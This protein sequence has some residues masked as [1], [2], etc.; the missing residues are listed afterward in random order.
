MSPRRPRPYSTR[1]ATR[2]CSRASPTTTCRS[3]SEPRSRWRRHRSCSSAF[4]TTAEKQPRTKVRAPRCITRC[5]RRSAKRLSGLLWEE[6]VNTFTK[7]YKVTWWGASDAGAIYR[8]DKDGKTDFLG[9]LR[10]TYPTI[11]SVLDRGGV[12]DESARGDVDE[13][14]RLPPERSAGSGQR[15]EALP[16]DVRIPVRASRCRTIVASRPAP[17]VADSTGCTEPK[18]S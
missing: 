16:D 10:R 12:Y 6:I 13:S 2:R 4:I 11:P 9:V 14:H 3:R 18:F 1:W 17:V 8:P 5:S 7:N 15:G